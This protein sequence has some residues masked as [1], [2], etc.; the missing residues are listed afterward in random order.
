[1]V[2][3]KSSLH[4]M[5]G[6]ARRGEAFDSDDGCPFALQREHCARLHRHAVDMDDAGA[7]LRGVAADMG[8]GE[9]QMLPKKFHQQRSA[10]DLAADGASVHC[11]RDHRH[12]S[13]SS[14][15]GPLTP[16]SPCT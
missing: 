9:V 14:I 15:R 7:A 6:R 1:M 12:H 3:P 10:F 16:P 2:L 4:G 11:H 8:A 13:G 5:H